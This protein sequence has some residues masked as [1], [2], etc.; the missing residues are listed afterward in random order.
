VHKKT[1]QYR[2]YP[3]KAQETAIERSIGACRWVYNKVLETRKTAYETDKTS[4]TLFDT[5]KLLPAWKAEHGFLKKAHSQALQNACVRVDLAFKAFFRRVKAGETPGFPRFRSRFRYDSL[6]FPGSGFK[7]TDDGKLDVSKIGR[8]KIILHRPI[9][10]AI[11]TLTVKRTSTGKWFASFSCEV[12]AKPLVANPKA[13]GIDVGLLNFATLSTGEVVENPRF[14]KQARK[15]LAKVSRRI[16]KHEKGT[17]ERRFHRQAVAL[18]HEKTANRRKDF[19]HKLSHRLVRDFGILCFEDLNV[20]N[21]SK[22]A[23]GTV[24]NPGT[25]V[26]QK[27]GLNRSIFDAAWTQLTQFTSNKAESAGRKF[28]WVNPRN[29]SKMCSRCGALVDKDLSVRV[30]NCSSCGLKMNRDHNAAL[31]ILRLGLESLALGA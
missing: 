2:I 31:N 29:T 7:L 19:A 24:E 23:A 21:M 9:E 4:L 28:A 16:A 6:T 12:E 8:V 30:H 1:F 26:A 13:V 3:T 11:K 14:F 22:S 18:T 10:G 5:I 17:P 20:K 15:A 27:T 25:N